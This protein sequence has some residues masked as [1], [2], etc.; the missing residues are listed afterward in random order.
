LADGTVGLQATATDEAGNTS[1]IR[2]GSTP[3][4]TAAPTSTLSGSD[5]KYNYTD[6]TGT[7]ADQV[8]GDSGAV[9]L[10]A[11]D[12][13]LTLTATEQTGPHP[14]NVYQGSTVNGNGSFPAFSVDASTVTVSYTFRLYDLAG[15]PGNTITKTFPATK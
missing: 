7:T 11:G 15:N 13:T 12:G 8:S 1:G 5:K 9:S 14:G 4:D 3:K 10:V 6:N 2:T